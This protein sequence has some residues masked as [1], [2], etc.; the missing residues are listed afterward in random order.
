MDMRA[1]AVFVLLCLV[2]AGTAAAE[3]PAPGEKKK[4]KSSDKSGVQ[5]PAEP[6][7]SPAKAPGFG[8]GSMAAQAAGAA[9]PVDENRERG[10]ARS[11]RLDLTPQRQFQSGKLGDRRGKERTS[12]VG[13]GDD[14]NWGV[15]AAQVGAMV[16]I[17]GALVA[18][19]A[20][21]GCLLPEL[22]GG[23]DRL[24]PAPG[25]GQRDPGPVRDG[26]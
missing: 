17:F 24:G 8:L 26:R 5:K 6:P 13:L 23:Q 9:A 3:P 18:I 16:G 1:I 21:G 10:L 19:C 2:A 25:V 22:F 20:D 12:G 15:Q 4:P 14:G 7:A 11:R